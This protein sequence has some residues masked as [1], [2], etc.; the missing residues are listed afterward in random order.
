MLDQ[1][2]ALAASL[3]RR[4]PMLPQEVALQRFEQLQPQ[5][6]RALHAARVSGDAVTAMSLLGA[7]ARYLW[8][9]GHTRSIGLAE[10]DATL[11]VVPEADARGAR[12]ELFPGYLGA[13]QLYYATAAY[14]RARDALAQVAPDDPDALNLQ[15][16][17]EREQGNCAAA[18]HL[19]H[20][21][22][23]GYERCSDRWGVAHAISNLGVCAFRAGDVE[24]ATALH[25]QALELRRD[26]EDL[27]GIGSS[28][29]NLALIHSGAGAFDRAELLYLESL[30]VRE[31]LGDTWGIAGSC[32]ALAAVEVARCRPACALPLLLRASEQFERVGDRLGY[33]ETAEAAA[34]ALLAA[35][36]PEAAARA[37]GA[38]EGAR[39]VIAA[40]VPGSH[41][42]PHQ[43]LVDQLAAFEDARRRGVE[44]GE[45]GAG[46]ALRETIQRIIDRDVDRS[47]AGESQP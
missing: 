47:D 36:Q 40:P 30:G 27:L 20:R 29:G 14:D 5:A 21:A 31:A 33:A 32:V 25:E 7:L 10:A 12:R 23:A 35:G 38:A 34:A 3:R 6:L 4:A 18:E 28:L 9:R 45:R 39:R 15:G 24:R 13:A 2:D 1:L 19:H 44:D 42:Q 8:M 17:I 11:A 43:R 22:R 41:R 46:S 37:L 16:M 26:I